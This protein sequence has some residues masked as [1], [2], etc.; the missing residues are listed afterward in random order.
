MKVLNYLAVFI[1]VVFGFLPFLYRQ[2][3]AFAAGDSDC[4]LVFDFYTR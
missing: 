1:F 3:F 4:A 2:R